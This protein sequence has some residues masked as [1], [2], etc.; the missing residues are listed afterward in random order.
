MG[1]LDWMFPK[2]KDFFGMLTKQAAITVRGVEY[3]SRYMCGEESVSMADIIDME[4]QGD[5]TRRLLIDDLNKTFITPIE[6]EDI[7]SLS[8]AIDDIIDLAKSALE[9]FRIYKLEPDE[10]LQTMARKIQ[11][12][13]KHLHE[14][15]ELLRDHA[16]ISVEMCTKT[17]DQIDEVETLHYQSLSQLA[18]CPDVR[19]MFLMREIYKH[20]FELSRRVD[21]ASNIVLDI[22]VKM[23]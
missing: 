19:H 16:A 22:I 3:F 17:K 11:V 23:T 18:D 6:R 7:F 5:R 14:A 13:V 15:I 12:A 21:D 8:R 20:L 1:L 4:H 9:E 2:E 10:N